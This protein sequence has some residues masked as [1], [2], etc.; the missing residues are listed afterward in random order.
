MD[1]LA[2][3][4]HGLKVAAL[5]SIPVSVGLRLPGPKENGVWN[6]GFLPEVRYMGGN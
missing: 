3:E 6:A 1:N 2:P 5:A 4:S